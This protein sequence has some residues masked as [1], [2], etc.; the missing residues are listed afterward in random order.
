MSEKERQV[1]KCATERGLAMI[2]RER[3]VRSLENECPEINWRDNDG[4]MS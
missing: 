3:T 4:R 1:E 2:I